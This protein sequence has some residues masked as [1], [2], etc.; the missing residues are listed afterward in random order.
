M[1]SITLYLSKIYFI[2]KEKKIYLLF[3]LLS[4]ITLSILDII[5]I[6]LVTAFMSLLLGS[7][8]I[9]FESIKSIFQFINITNQSNFLNF[10]ILSI[11]TLYTCKAIVTY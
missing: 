9:I 1:N 3:L 11:L 10:L 8:N 5:G 6:S 2:L 7:N 4:F